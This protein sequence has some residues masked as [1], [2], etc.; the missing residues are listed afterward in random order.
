MACRVACDGV[1]AARLYNVRRAIPFEEPVAEH[2]L[3][4]HAALRSRLPRPPAGLPAHRQTDGVPLHAVL[5]A[6][7][8]VHA[9]RRARKGGEQ[10]AAPGLRAMARDAREV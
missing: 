8:R 7:G 1:A 9:V 5:E 3:Q 4:R 2:L 6:R 10:L